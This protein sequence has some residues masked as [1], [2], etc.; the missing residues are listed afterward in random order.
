MQIIITPFTFNICL[1][2][3]YKV[4]LYI[5]FYI[6]V[7]KRV[8]S[9]HTLEMTKVSD[10]KERSNY[11]ECGTKDLIQG[12]YVCSLCRCGRSSCIEAL[13]VHGAG[14]WC[15][16]YTTRRLNP[17][18]VPNHSATK[19]KLFDSTLS[20]TPLSDHHQNHSI[21][22]EHQILRIALIVK[23]SLY[24]LDGFTINYM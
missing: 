16:L 10:S 7:W 24:N 22:K 12:H 4:I 23:I 8:S 19:L 2:W 5:I 18:R 6:D 21:N 14:T 15:W 13:F 9:S 20:I 17:I 3:I 1:Y 11:Y